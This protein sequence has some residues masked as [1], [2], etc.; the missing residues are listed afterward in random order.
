MAVLSGVFLGE[1][2]SLIRWLAISV[3]FAGALVIVQ[4]GS[5]AFRPAALWGIAAAICVAF[6]GASGEAPGGDRTGAGDLLLHHRR[7]CPHRARAGPG[8]SRHLADGRGNQPL[9]HRNRRTA[10]RFRP[11]PHHLRLPQ[12]EASFV[13]PFEYSSLLVA[14]V[15]GYLVFGDV[16][17]IMVAIGMMLVALAGIILARRG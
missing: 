17:T 14:V 3:G 5:D 9:A 7:L 2:V 11:L 13:V 10:R 4:P 1:R 16:P 15:L 6:N 12:G 8:R